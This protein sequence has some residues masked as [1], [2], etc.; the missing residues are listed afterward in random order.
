MDILIENAVPL[1]N[2]D[3]ALIFAV[4]DEFEKRGD[5]VYYSTFDYENVRRQY[6]QKKWIKSP[7]S[8]KIITKIPGINILYLMIYLISHPIY[9]KFDAVVSA[10]GGYVNSFYGVRKKL[11]LLTLFNKLLKK[12]IYM[13]SQSIGPLTKSDQRALKNIIDSF[14]MFYVR[15]E[16]SM[17]RIKRLSNSK[18]IYKT[19]DAAFLTYSNKNDTTKKTKRVAIS[20]REWN[21]KPKE[22]SNFKNNIKDIVVFLIEN[23]FQITFISTCQGVRGY[24]DDSIIA[25]GIVAEL[26]DSGFDITNIIVDESY[27][28]YDQLIDKINEFDFVIGTR[29]HMC[30]LALINGIPAFNISYEEKGLECFKYLGIEKYSISYGQRDTQ[31]TDR[32]IEFI[33]NDDFHTTFDRIGDIQKES[34]IYF[35]KLR[36]DILLTRG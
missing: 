18:N 23:G 7:L 24:T 10:P 22:V 2:G 33:R 3:A 36:K 15:D 31:I 12:P 8:N 14:R 29:L 6:K 26:S 1:N 32:I 35:D 21:E 34:Q 9:R 17:D 11:N 30:I 20:V 28:T 16:L 27:R 19:K 4:G 25:K 5:T 13:Y